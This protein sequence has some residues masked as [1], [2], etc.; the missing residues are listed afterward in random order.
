MPNSDAV[1]YLHQYYSESAPQHAVFVSGKWGAGKSWYVRDSLREPDMPCIWISLYGMRNT[2]ELAD[3]VERALNPKANSALGQ[4]GFMAARGIFK[5]Y[6]G[7]DLKNERRRK[8]AFETAQKTSEEDFIKN[9]VFVFDDL[10]RTSMP[11]VDALGFI[12][13]LTEYSKARVVIIGN[14][15]EL[16]SADQTFQKMQ[17]KLIGKTLEISAAASEAIPAFLSEV[18]DFTR[19]IIER[20]LPTIQDIFSASKLDNLR[21]LRAAFRDADRLLSRLNT[22]LRQKTNLSIDLIRIFVAVSIELRAARITPKTLTHL[23][24]YDPFWA[25]RRSD[26]DTPPEPHEV[27]MSKYQQLL[28]SDWLLNAQTWERLFRTGLVDTD[29][30]NNELS[31]CHYFEQAESD[32]IA[33]RKY[34]RLED[35]TFR[36]TLEGSLSSLDGGKIQDPTELLLF[37]ATLLQLVEDELLDLS[38]DQI[39]MKAIEAFAKIEPENLL[40]KIDNIDEDGWAIRSGARTSTIESI[41]K[42]REQFISKARAIEL[43]HFKIGIPA[44]L[45]GFAQNPKGLLSDLSENGKFRARPVLA[46]IEPV[47]LVA[48]VA[49]LSMEDAWSFNGTLRI[50]YQHPRPELADEVRWLPGLIE[51]L[52]NAAKEHLKTPRGHLLAVTANNLSSTCTMWRSIIGLL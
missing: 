50:R 4:L 12:N 17:E 49:R 14:P 28:P 25:G 23:A 24:D 29:Q 51:A 35:H 30:I 40:N 13:G 36:Q 39:E 10:E 43:E 22:A 9:G 37:A 15:E 46:Q 16:G 11:L 19:S 38:V 2:T 32:W 20:S 1:K 31:K 45:V 41:E 33:L 34:W 18:S 5:R 26:K 27:F 8:T 7:F 52:K 44:L 21:S 3:A 6:V 42:I 47:N 48:V